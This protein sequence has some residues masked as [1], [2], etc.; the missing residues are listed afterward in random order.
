VKALLTSLGVLVL[1]LVGWLVWPRP[2]GPA[3]LHAGTSTSEVTV[4]VTRPRLG[5]TDLAIDLRSPS[6]AAQPGAFVQAQAAM[7]L[8][9][10]ATPQVAATAA[11]GGRYTVV[12]V[13]LMTTGQW[14]LHLSITPP[15]GVREDLLLPFDVTG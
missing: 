7:P 14:E 6:G 11:G 1:G 10:F 8:M 2:P 9:G 5:A 12:A 3:T 15:G 13:H 4:T